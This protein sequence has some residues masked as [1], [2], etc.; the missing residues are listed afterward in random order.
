MTDFQIP[1]HRHMDNKWLVHRLAHDFQLLDVWEYPIVFDESDNDSLYAFRKFAV[2]PTLKDAFNFSPSGALFF[3]RTVFGKVFRIDENVNNVPI[4]GC[5]EISLAERMSETEQRR[6]DDELNIDIRTDNYLDFR[7]VYSFQ[8]ETLNEISNATEHTLMHYAWVRDDSGY[9]KVQM[10]NYVKHRN[11]VGEIYVRSIE[12]FRY[13]VVY[14]YLFNKFVQ[15]WHHYKQLQKP[16]TA[17]VD[18]V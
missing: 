8:N 7:P 14:P 11:K 2:E 5:S 15:H 13:R 9:Y 4:P 6:H 1:N 16:A 17:N 3:L 18:A 12:P 10:A